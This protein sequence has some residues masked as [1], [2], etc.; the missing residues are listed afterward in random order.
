MKNLI[1]CYLLA[2]R[3]PPRNSAWYA[4]HQRAR[5]RQPWVSSEP[6]GVA[7]VTADSPI[8]NSII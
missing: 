2:A 6:A 7:E 1:S 3:Q 4:T 5:P 8:V